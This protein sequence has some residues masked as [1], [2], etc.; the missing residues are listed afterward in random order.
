MCQQVPPVF[1]TA[2]HR[3]TSESVCIEQTQSWTQFCQ[4]NTIKRVLK[5]GFRR[6][7]DGLVAQGYANFQKMVWMAII[8][9]IGKC[10]IVIHTNF[11]KF[12]YPCATRYADFI[13]FSPKPHLKCYHV[14]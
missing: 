11:W 14:L 12:E 13:G 9:K 2:T 10:K 3:N 5:M 7:S 8:L 4:K 1:Y 6:K